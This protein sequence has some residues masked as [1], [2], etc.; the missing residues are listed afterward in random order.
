MTDPAAQAS[1][2]ERVQFLRR[3]GER[4]LDGAVRTLV[5]ARPSRV[6]GWIAPGDFRTRRPM[7]NAAAQEDLI[8][9]LRIVKWTIFFGACMGLGLFVGVNFDELKLQFLLACFQGRELLCPW[10]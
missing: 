10:G 3:Q 9:D 1:N 2:R 4:R 5:F 8:K 7:L 6:P